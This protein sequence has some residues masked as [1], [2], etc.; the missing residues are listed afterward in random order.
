MSHKNKQQKVCT[1]RGFTLVELL[2][3]VFILL[4]ALVAAFTAAQQSIFASINARDQVIAFYLSQ[5]AF[6]LVKNVR[7]SNLQEG[8]ESGRDWWEQGLQQCED[9]YCTI[10]FNVDDPQDSAE[11]CPDSNDPSSCNVLEWNED[12]RYYGHDQGVDTWSDTRFR[13]YF[14][15]EV[16]NL[17]AP[18][19]SPGSGNKDDEIKVTVTVE[20]SVGIFP[21]TFTV[22]EYIT[23]WR[24]EPQT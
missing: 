8:L 18:T 10:T 4:I 15:I 9:A 17:A 3:S 21:K 20:W 22:S 2:V 16:P 19:G 11:A 24:F 1:Q 12:G 23:K 6:E 14:E 13:R 7:D 5:E